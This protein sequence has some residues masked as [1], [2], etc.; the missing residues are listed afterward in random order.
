MPPGLTD[1]WHLLRFQHGRGGDG[2]RSRCLHR[3][4]DCRGLG[5]VP[6]AGW[7]LL[8]SLA[9]ASVRANAGLAFGAINVSSSAMGITS[10]CL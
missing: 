9:L 2:V 1:R 7:A 8:R 6:Q 10:W 3:P 5:G 4:E